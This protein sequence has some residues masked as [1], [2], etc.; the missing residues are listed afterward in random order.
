MVHL[1]IIYAGEFLMFRVC[2][3]ILTLDGHAVQS[4]RFRD[5]IP[6][7]ELNSVVKCINDLMPDEI[8]IQ[9]IDGK[10]CEVLEELSS[11]LKNINLP[12]S[13][14]GGV[15]SLVNVRGS[16]DYAERYIFNSD[17]FLR[18]KIESKGV[19]Q[20][21]G[22]Q[23]CIGYLPFRFDNQLRTFIFFNSDTQSFDSLDVDILHK[24]FNSFSEIVLLDADAQ[25]LVSGFNM[26]ILKIFEGSH[27]SRIYVS[28][29]INVHT[30]AMS[31]EIGLAGVVLDNSSLFFSDRIYLR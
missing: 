6:L 24:I 9:A 3:Q 31:K 19:R 29:G 20:K 21:Y 17:I 8:H 14:G 27:Y 5:I 28:G 2:A 13:V 15:K 25:G 26:D 10:I 18:E 1:E 16:I 7:G 11:V 30:I 22:L 4:F 23:A 12:L